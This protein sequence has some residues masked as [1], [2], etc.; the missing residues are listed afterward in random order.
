MITAHAAAGSARPGHRTW[1]AALILFLTILLG[2]LGLTGAN[3]LWAQ[4]GAVTA[5]VSTGK[6]VDYSRSGFSMPL[7]IAVDDAKDVPWYPTR[8]S[9]RLS[10]T[11][12]AQLD[13]GTQKITYRVDA[14]KIS[15]LEVRGSALPYQG[16]A[17]AV[18][19]ET[20]RPYFRTETLEITVT[21][22]VNGVTG[23]PTVK[24]LWLDSSGKTWLSDVV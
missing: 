6:W 7:T 11:T 1:R 23:T 21:P 15:A 24:V 16:S 13:P 4:S 22:F 19:F 5:Q 10:W 17:A 9:I 12:A 8:R 20:T 3:A 2:G 14:R 18:T